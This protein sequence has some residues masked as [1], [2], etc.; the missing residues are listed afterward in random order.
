MDWSSPYLGYVAAAYGITGIV[1][2]SVLVH[3]VWRS[4][5]LKKTLRDMKLP[6]TGARDA[7]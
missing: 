4:A 3:T 7:K 6:D 2:L 5:A 1:L